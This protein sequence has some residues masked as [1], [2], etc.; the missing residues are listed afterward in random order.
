MIYKC[1][2]SVEETKEIN[3][4]ISSPKSSFH[5]N[6]PS[7][8]FKMEILFKTKMWTMPPLRLLVEKETQ[9]FLHAWYLVTL[10]PTATAHTVWSIFVGRDGRYS[11]FKPMQQKVAM[12]NEKLWR[13]VLIGKAMHFSAYFSVTISQNWRFLFKVRVFESSP[14]L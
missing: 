7:P 9:S 4:F 13:R 1:V 8:P 6:F 5:F 14:V 11:Y 10:V 12:N 2:F 3:L